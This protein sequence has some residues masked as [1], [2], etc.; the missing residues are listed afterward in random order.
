MAKPKPVP[1]KAAAKPSKERTYISQTDVP[2]VSIDKALRIAHA[3]RDNYGNGPAKP[4]DVA[5]ALEVTPTSSGFKMLA[6]ASIAYGFTEGGRNAAQIALTPLALKILKP[7]E[8]SHPLEG[9]R[10]ALLKPRVIRITRD[11]NGPRVKVP[12]HA[13]A[14]LS[15]LTRVVK[16]T[17]SRNLNIRIVKQRRSKSQ[18]NEPVVLCWLPLS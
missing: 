13:T 5:K 4:L 8:E 9:K 10:E 16:N 15:P 3:I 7:K 1:A 12:C 2:N 17:N 18:L 14:H 6:G 11:M